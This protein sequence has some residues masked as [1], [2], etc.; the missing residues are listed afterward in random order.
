VGPVFGVAA[1]VGEDKLN[2]RVADLEPGE[3]VGE[4]VTVDIFELEQ[5][6]VSRL[7]DYGGEWQL[8]QPLHLEGKRPVRER[9]GQVVETFVTAAP[10]PKT[11]SGDIRELNVRPPCAPHPER[12]NVRQYFGPALRVDFGS[13]ALALPR[14]M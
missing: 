4:P 8:G 5:C 12:T 11:R 2:F 14:L 3:L 13:V 7:D 6:R 10:E 9:A 1:G